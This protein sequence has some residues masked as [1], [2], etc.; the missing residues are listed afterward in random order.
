VRSL[1]RSFAGSIFVT[2]HF[3]EHGFS[4][5]P[6]ILSRAGALQAVHAADGD[7]IVRGRIYIAPPDYHLMFAPTHVR[8]VR[9]PRD[10]GNRPAADP[11]FRS[12]AVTF[13]PRVIGVVLS[14]SLDDGTAGLASVKRHG[15]LAIVEDPESALFPSMPR[16]ALEHVQVDR[17]VPVR[18][19][20]K[21]L[22]ELMAEPIPIP[23]PTISPAQRDV[24][25]N[26]LAAGNL[27]AITHAEEQHP[28]VVSS[29]SCPDCGGVLWEIR[30]GEFVRFRC[31]VG[32]AWTGDALFEEQR[33][34]LDEALWVALRSLE[35]SA[36]LARQIAARQRLRGSDS[37]A[38]RFEA[39]AAAT[40][41][42]A[43]VVRNVLATAAERT[44]AAENEAL[45][46]LPNPKRAS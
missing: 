27:R 10:N 17:V 36:S 2:L 9:G 21:V 32:H 43:E 13:G 1:P 4:V 31:R 8:L 30:D 24:V 19:L 33:R 20:A 41:S 28:G 22:E 29:F 5:L 6:R 11:M 7:A 25:E 34:V 39:Q 23:G 40:E 37:L 16:S 15:G 35:E 12:A 44:A 46:R 14:G 3:P 18:Q 42:R 45:E 38:M 26:E